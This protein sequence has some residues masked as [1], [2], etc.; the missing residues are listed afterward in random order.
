MAAMAQPALPITSLPSPPWQRPPILRTA[1]GAERRVGV[2]IEFAGLDV[3]EACVLVRRLYGGTIEP[4]NRFGSMVCGTTLGDFRVELDSLPLKKEKYKRYLEK[5]GAGSRLTGV[6]ED[7]LESIVS[8]FVPAE[9]VTAPIPIADAP[10][11]ESLRWA[12]HARNAEGT[13]ASILYTFGFQLNPELPALDAG[14]LVRHLRAFL[15]LQDWLFVV[16]EVDA[17]RD[18]YG[19]TEPFPDAYRRKVLDPS[20]APDEDALIGDYL[21]ANPTRNRALD[22]LP[23]FA[24][25]QEERVLAAAKE[26]ENVKAR[27]TFHYRLPNCLIDDPAWSFAVEWNR[28]VEVEKLADDPSRMRIAADE[29]LAA[30]E[31]ETPSRELTLERARRWGIEAP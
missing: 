31:G 26:A 29:L 28:W 5:V 4:I 9:I 18:W 6:V 25:L 14:T 12:L 8:T 23:V 27:P 19:W 30:A 16:A 15:A 2:E 13:K 17:T 24:T 11:L 3:D 20:Y 10:R 21:E 22:M 1:D 7:V